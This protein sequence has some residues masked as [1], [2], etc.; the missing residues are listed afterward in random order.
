MKSRWLKLRLSK[1]RSYKNE[2][3]KSKRLRDANLLTTRFNRWTRKTRIS[4]DDDHI[5][6]TKLFIL[7][8]IIT[9][10]IYI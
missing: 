10:S 4:Y 7:K 3:L 6:H 2:D 1:S 9:I 8:K 5:D